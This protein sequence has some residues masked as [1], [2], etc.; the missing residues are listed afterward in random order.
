MRSTWIGLSTSLLDVRRGQNRW[1]ELGVA[2]RLVER[3]FEAEL[4][5]S[6]G[7]FG[8]GKGILVAVVEADL[9][10]S[11]APFE[12]VRDRVRTDFLNRRLKDAA[13][14]EA[15]SAF[16]AAGDLAGAASRLGRDVTNSGD[17][18]PGDLVEGAGLMTAAMES[19]WFS[20]SAQVGDTGVL[21]GEAGAVVYSV[22]DR[23]PFD[24]AAFDDARSGLEAELVHERKSLLLQ[25][26]LNDLL[27][28]YSVLTNDELV[29]GVGA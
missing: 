28:D 27:D 19:A 5:G 24:P 4:G 21:E 15:R 6:T 22:T 1:E 9:E 23:V 26:I 2:P 13:L 12:D 3:V 25:Q 11:V 14:A 10:T 7:A 20:D 29:D 16:D 17:L 8:T 18:A